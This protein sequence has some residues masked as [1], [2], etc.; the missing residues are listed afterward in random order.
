M[1]SVERRVFEHVIDRGSCTEITTCRE[2]ERPSRMPSGRR[3]RQIGSLGHRKTMARVTHELQRL[4]CPFTTSQEGVVRDPSFS[5]GPVKTAPCPSREIAFERAFSSVRIVVPGAA[6]AK[7]DRRHVDRNA[8]TWCDGPPEVTTGLVEHDRQRRSGI[9]CAQLDRP[10][11]PS[12]IEPRKWARS[13]VERQL[14]LLTRSSQRRARHLERRLASM[15][16]ITSVLGEDPM[17]STHAIVERNIDRRERQ[18]IS[19]ATPS[20]SGVRRR[21]NRAEKRDRGYRIA[22]AVTDTVEVPPRVAVA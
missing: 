18:R 9:V 3:C 13:F 14:D 21:K 19:R 15:K 1:A 22:A 11:E 8:R 12:R 5:V 17:R 4:R 7:T 20:R 10:F 6:P 2:I 16:R